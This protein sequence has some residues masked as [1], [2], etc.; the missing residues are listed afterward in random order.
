VWKRR[1]FGKGEGAQP[2][3]AVLE[4][5]RSTVASKLK[6]IDSV[7]RAVRERAARR[8]RLQLRKEPLAVPDGGDSLADPMLETLRIFAELESAT[9]AIET[10]ALHILPAAERARRLEAIRGLS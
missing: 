6:A 10:R 4:E 2:P 7:V 8:E 5:I 3:E 1:P 9:S